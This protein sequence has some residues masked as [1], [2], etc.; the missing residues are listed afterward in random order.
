M[1]TSE[2]M[3]HLSMYRAALEQLRFV[4]AVASSSQV[5]A[6]TDVYPPESESPTHRSTTTSSEQPH[7]HHCRQSRHHPSNSDGDYVHSSTTV[8]PTTSGSRCHS[9][10]NIVDQQTALRSVQLSSTSSSSLRSSFSIDRILAGGTAAP[11]ST[12]L[13]SATDQPEQQCD[14]VIRFADNHHHES[15]GSDAQIAYDDAAVIGFDNCV[16]NSQ[17]DKSLDLPSTTFA[18]RQQHL[19]TSSEL[20]GGE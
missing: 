12:R 6:T 20:F 3:Q 15:L 19:K 1:W 9:P 5:A 4:A 11:T 13:E 10:P 8:S 14:D 18:D 16:A 2:P 17:H 7:H